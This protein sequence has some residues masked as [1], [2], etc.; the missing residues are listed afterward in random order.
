MPTYRND[1]N[2]KYHLSNETSSLK[3]FIEPGETLETIAYY[4]YPN[5]VLTLD[6]PYQEFIGSS[7]QVSIESVT[8]VELTTNGYPWIECDVNT[9]VLVYY[10]S[11]TTTPERRGVGVFLI[12]NQDNK[13]NKIIIKT[14]AGTGTLIYSVKKE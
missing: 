8:G 13:A 6:T 2:V 12:N 9:P 10:N 11:E 1:S 5:L 3:R 7:D 4:N 14:I